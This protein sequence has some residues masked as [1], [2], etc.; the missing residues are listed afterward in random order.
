MSVDKFRPIIN[1]I[2]FR[3]QLLTKKIRNRTPDKIKDIFRQFVLPYT[4]I[5]IIGLFVCVSNYVQAAESNAQYLPNDQVMDLNPLTVAKTVIAINP[6]T[7]NLQGD[8]VQVALAMQNDQFLGKPVITDTAN[9]TVATPTT[10]T[11]GDRKA[12]I[13]YTV[14]AGDTI[15]SIGWDYGL[16]IATIKSLNN[17]SSDNIKLGQT[18]K[19]PPQDIS[20]ALIKQLA[21]KAANSAVIKVNAHP[22]SSNNAY[23]RGWC[24]YYVATRRY[25]PGHWGNAHDWLG[26]AKRAGY[27]TGSNPAPGAIVVFS[28]SFYGHVAYV[29]SVSGNSITISE[30][31]YRGWNMID[32]RTIS[33]HGGGIMGYVY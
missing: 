28:V 15:S 13:S 22:G 24:T 8:A 30:M 33:A 1:Q 18:L 31:N 19:L 7:P 20:P 29:E 6:Y 27:K 21:A 12:T 32:R 23:P 16:K 25:V 9:T 17:L 10:D 14:K 26:S 5:I 2:V 3:Y 11:S 4:S